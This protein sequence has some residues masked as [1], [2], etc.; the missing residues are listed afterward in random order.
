LPVSIRGKNKITDISNEIGGATISIP[1]GI[2]DLGELISVI[3]NELKTTLNANAYYAYYLW[4]LFLSKMPLGI[5]KYLTRKSA[6]KTSFICTNLVGPNKEFKIAGST[7]KEQYVIPALMPG[8]GLGFGFMKSLGKMQI[9]VI[10]DPGVIEDV[11]RFKVSL[12]RSLEYFGLQN[13]EICK[14][15]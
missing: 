14:E 11:G 9:A 15:V 6:E 1:L 8:H 5:R 10:Y 13:V 4:A 2:T 7:I 12:V 3:Q